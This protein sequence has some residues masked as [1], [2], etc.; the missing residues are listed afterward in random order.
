MAFSILPPE[1]LGI[2]TLADPKV[3]LRVRFVRARSARATW[4]ASRTLQSKGAGATAA[5]TP[6]INF[7]DCL[8]ELGQAARPISTGELRALQRFHI[9]PINLVVYEGSL[10]PCGRDT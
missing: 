6:N 5:R 10:V 8:R 3:T 9:R 7:N 1:T 2:R 4:G